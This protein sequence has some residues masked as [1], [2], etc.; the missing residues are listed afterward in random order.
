[1]SYWAGFALLSHLV[2]KPLAIYGA[3]VGL[4]AT[5]EEEEADHALCFRAASAA[6]VRSRGSAELLE[7]LGIHDVTGHGRPGVQD[8][9][10]TQCRLGDSGQRAR[11]DGEKRIVVAIRSWGDDGFV[12]GLAEQLDR[13]VASHDTSVVFLPFQMSPHRSENDPALALRVLA[14]DETALPG[15]HP[16]RYLHARGQDGRPIGT[17]TSSSACGFIPSSWPQSRRRCARR[18]PKRS[19]STRRSAPSARRRGSGI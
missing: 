13:L 14:R 18:W 15:S 16:Q 8:E 1:M 9:G 7:Q 6:S 5:D 10:P 3:G 17:A 12:P 2:D 11:S 19:R 4:L